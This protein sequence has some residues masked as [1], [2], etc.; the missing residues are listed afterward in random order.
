MPIE[1]SDCGTLLDIELESGRSIWCDQYVTSSTYAHFEIRTPSERANSHMLLFI[2]NEAKQLFGDWPLHI[3]H[4]VRESGEI[5]YP[6]VRMTAFFTSS[7]VDRRM[8]LSSLIV[9]WFQNSQHP[10]PDR[11]ASETLRAL[12][13]E[14]LAVDYG[15]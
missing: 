7:P 13:W 11:D 15:W 10:I 6:S 3:V 14:R 8:D 12:P 4:P 2:E 9:A 1:D 5:D